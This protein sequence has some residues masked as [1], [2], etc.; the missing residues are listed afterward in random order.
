MTPDTPRATTTATSVR[1]RIL[2]SLGVFL[3][4]LV[5]HLWIQFQVA[6]LYGVDGYYHIKVAQLYGNGELSLFGGTFPWMAFGSYGHT[7]A[8][9]QTGYH[10]LLVPFTWL[11]L[12]FGA[13][14]SAA[15]F[16]ALTP[17]VIHGVLRARRVPF[18]WAFGLGV[19]LT[20]E[21]YL[22][23]VN[24]VR[25]APL[26][27]VFLILIVHFGT[28]ERWRALF[29]TTLGLVFV[30]TVP[31]NVVA[32]LGI[33][34]VA[35]V[36][37]ERRI[38]WRMVAAGVGALLIGIVAHPGFW[39]WQ[40]SFFGADH[41][42][43]RIWEQMGASIQAAKDGFVMMSDGTRLS[44][45]SPG[46]LKPPTREMIVMDFLPPLGAFA[47]A[48]LLLVSRARKRMGSF[49]PATIAITGLYLVLFSSHL[50]FFEYWIPF[51]FVAAGASFGR[52]VGDAPGELWRTFRGRR[53]LQGLAFVLVTSPLVFLGVRGVDAVRRTVTDP[54]AMVGSGPR[55]RKCM[56]WL[57]ENSEEGELVF[58]AR[59]PQFAPMFFFN[60]WNTYLIGFDAYFMFQYDP[61][62]YRVWT[63][64]GAGSLDPTRTESVIRRMG[65][66]WALS[67]RK[68]VLADRLREAPNTALVYEDRFFSVFRID[69]PR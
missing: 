16:A 20:S 26:V 51:A 67:R 38:P 24:L 46:E 35:F 27:V 40:G 52:A 3:A 17:T 36:A 41:A 61:V 9:W 4:A 45:P 47:L 57:E 32:V 33:M 13:K 49:L 14:L 69:A 54:E 66:R 64:A 58:H 28:A 11:G 1:A 5:F 63:I 7:R 59:W 65:A 43:F 39:H 44:F 34:G 8:D 42:L 37:T 21:L 19:C 25:P 48:L 62:S 12:V 23:R 29:C 60:H 31:H 15:L 50:R 55:Y 18:A 6:A 10:I 56:A 2:A 22:G 30:Y 68:G 53:L